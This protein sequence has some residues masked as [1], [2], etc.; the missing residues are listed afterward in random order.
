MSEIQNDAQDQDLRAAIDRVPRPNFRFSPPAAEISFARGFALGGDLLES[1]Q[2]AGLPIGATE[3]H[4]QVRAKATRMLA[5]DAVA[6]RYAYFKALLAAKMDCREDR[7]IT[8][9]ASIGFSDIADF[10]D[11][12]GKLKNIHDIP[13]H[14]RAAIES[15]SPVDG[16]IKL[17]SKMQ[18]LSKMVAIKNMDAGNQ[19]S[20]APKIVIGLPGA[21]ATAA[22][23]YLEKK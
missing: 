14:A 12:S 2:Q 19:E 5:T 8:E 1:W 21:T 9:L 13:P 11:E 10:Y 15:Y 6:E 20:K 3:T 18:A 17:N 23:K 22:P 16:K 4:S 7:I